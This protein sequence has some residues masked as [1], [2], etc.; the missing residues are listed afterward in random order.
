VSFPPALSATVRLRL[1]FVALC[2]AW[3]TT[4]L[5]F[6]LAIAVVPPA[7]FSG[8]RWTVAGI[9]LLAWL[10]LNHR[11]V[12]VPRRL[13]VRVAVLSIIM[14]SV[15]ATVQ[16]YGL[17][18]VSSGLAAVISSA[19]TPIAT[20]GFAVAAGQERLNWR[21][22]LAFAVGVAGILV[23]FGPALATGRMDLVELLGAV[24]VAVSTLVWCGSSVLT[25]PLLRV[26]PPVQMAAISN[27]IGGVVLLALS[28]P[29]EPGAWRAAGMDWG[30][31]AWTSWLWL[32]FPCSLGASIIYFLL[33]RDWGASRTGTYAFLTPVIAVALGMVV[34]DERVDAIEALGMA[35]MLAGAMLA[36]RYTP[37]ATRTS[38]R[39][40]VTKA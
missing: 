33:V 28:L 24:A 11:R 20:L 8:V 39:P 37:F 12:Y 25:R 17:R 21:Q 30:W 27:L 3:G 22:C 14:I 35:L 13:M 15:N 1:M 6:K 16:L 5:G 19:L 26:I 23:L 4:W 9:M 34:L 7:F 32:T 29:F 38:R 36:L 18:V 10:R 2:V 31:V 40:A